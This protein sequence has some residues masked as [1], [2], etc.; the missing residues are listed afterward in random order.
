MRL[1]TKLLALIAGLMTALV[2][3]LS[4]AFFL[5]LERVNAEQ[6]ARAEITA[7]LNEDLRLQMFE[8]QRR[9]LELPRRL[10]GGGLEATLEELRAR[11]G[12]EEV[13]HEGRKAI[14]ARYSSRAARRDLQQP[15][16]TV[17][18]PIEGGAAVSFGAFAEGEFQDAIL[19]LRLPGADPEALQRTFAQLGEAGNGGQAVL[20]KLATLEEELV[21]EALAAETAR[22]AILDQVEAIAARD[23]AVEA[24][25]GNTRIFLAVLGV[26]ATLIASLVVWLV[27]RRAVTR[28]LLRL[29]QAAEALAADRET[30]IPEPARRDE[31]GI[32]ARALGV[33]RSSAVRRRELEA[34]QATQ[35]QEL[36][37]RG[38]ETAEAIAAFE[39]TVAA[40]LEEMSRTAGAF[41]GAAERLTATADNTSNRAETAADSAERAHGQT[42]AVAGGTTRLVEAIAALRAQAEDAGT[43]SASAVAASGRAGERISQLTKVSEV[44][45][46]FVEL[47]E[48]IAERTK[49]LAL[50][51]T[52]EA[53]RAGEAGRGFVVVANEV[54]SL[55][56]QTA[57]ATDRVAAQV[58]DM[59]TA[60]SVSVEAIGEIDGTVGRLGQVTDALNAAI[61]Q[62]TD[63]TAEIDD[64]TRN[65][66]QLTRAVAESI[67]AVKRDAEATRADAAAIAEASETLTGRTQALRGEV[68]RFL[69]RVRAA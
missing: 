58:Q 14:V 15:D 56:G 53:A 47:I 18:E 6:E 43:I 55:A 35:R 20:A 8:L 45:G 67:A 9:Y 48:D 60:M 46:S 32:L 16:K 42:D 59:R 10:T 62:Q 41:A 31:I 36:E 26:A 30:E 50:N 12:A 68:D 5:S 65:A 2:A 44:I 52:I 69:A 33:L 38:R 1:D 54:K 28:P 4:L 27:C 40:T 3:A 29:V 34:E 11:P 51:A 57:E 64:N 25:T 23:A 66:T 21:D 37:R 24:L 17:V 49:L 22:N 63:T 19:E 61:A 13:R 39:E 7:A